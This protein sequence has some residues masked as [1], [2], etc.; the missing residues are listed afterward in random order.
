MKT[1]ENHIINQK[2][3]IIHLLIQV[4][5]NKDHLKMSKKKLKSYMNTELLLMLFFDKIGEDIAF[6]D[7]DLP[8]NF[9]EIQQKNI[10]ENEDNNRSNNC[11]SF[12]NQNVEINVD[13]DYKHENKSESD[14]EI[15]QSN[16]EN[17][18]KNLN[19]LSIN[20]RRSP[21]DINANKCNN[22]N[23]PNFIDKNNTSIIN[24]P[25]NKLDNTNIL[26]K[27]RLI[28]NTNN[29]PHNPFDGIKFTKNSEV[30]YPQNNINR[31]FNP[32]LKQKIGIFSRKG[33]IELP[34]NYKTSLL[35]RF[36]IDNNLKKD[37]I[38]E[39][40][41]NN[42]DK[43]DINNENVQSYLNADSPISR[44]SNNEVISQ[45]NKNYLSNTNKDNDITNT[46]DCLKL[47][48][49][50]NKTT[51]NG[52]KQFQHNTN[53]F[54]IS[55]SD[56]FVDNYEYLKQNTI[57]TAPVNKDD[58]F[59]TKNCYNDDGN[60]LI[61]DFKQ[62]S[63]I[64][65]PLNSKI[66]KKFNNR[67]D[68]LREINNKYL[69]YK[70]MY[71]NIVLNET[72]RD[73]IIKGNADCNGDRINIVKTNTNN[74]VNNINM[75][76]KSKQQNNHSKDFHNKNI[77]R[78]SKKEDNKG[79]QV[80]YN[81]K[82][83][84][85]KCIESHSNNKT[86]LS[87]IKNTSNEVQSINSYSN[88]KEKFK[89]ILDNLID[90]TKTK[91][92]HADKSKNTSSDLSLE[93][94]KQITQNIKNI[95][96]NPQTDN[97]VY[98]NDMIGKNCNSNKITDS[99]KMQINHVKNG[100]TQSDQKNKILTSPITTFDIK[101]LKI[102]KSNQ[103][104]KENIPNTNSK[105]FKYKDLYD[106]SNSNISK[107]Q[108][109]IESI[110][111]KNNQNDSKTNPNIFKKN[112]ILTNKTPQN[113]ISNNIS[114]KN[115]VDLFNKFPSPKIKLQRKSNLISKQTIQNTPQKYQ[116]KKPDLLKHVLQKKIDKSQKMLE[117]VP[118]T[119]LPKIV[120]DRILG[121]FKQAQWA[122][123]E[124]LKEVTKLY[125][126]DDVDNIFQSDEPLD[127]RKMF[128]ENRNFSNDSP[129]KWV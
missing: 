82:E 9:G 68:Q 67:E 110:L 60:N 73:N 70:N 4:N 22:N 113:N 58:M 28:G 116:S 40:S 75:F 106:K 65:I 47:T 76:D 115:N 78:Y 88:N 94:N 97:Q 44:N 77:H 59:I 42:N 129:N 111:E 125:N 1:K 103:T 126:R 109:T 121:P 86:L 53:T 118:S 19:S 117:Y 100:N 27:N 89:N 56:S 36:S 108:N 17:Y 33:I 93:K 64:E 128:P 14:M 83:E 37:S 98:K 107:N 54:E 31:A 12:E 119:I 15:I 16:N 52:I 104:Q 7:A 61:R 29:K 50:I 95:V 79:I 34:A 46:I 2:H 20:N 62:I 90:S 30:N 84:Q 41:C 96:K 6:L 71:E 35:N 91:K 49:N 8:E 10:N 99:Q 39:N 25:I 21:N 124:H 48:P 81:I 11:N 45:N 80:G 5:P 112:A 51:V 127:I 24:Q 74:T 23:T 92:L 123:K 13:V 63:S 120:D 105:N 32:F 26:T 38:S 72:R 85:E 18:L 57:N 66:N 55:F 87:D 43:N 114:T 102:D 101:S 3:Q 122:S 69:K